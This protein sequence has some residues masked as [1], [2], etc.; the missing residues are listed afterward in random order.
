MPAAPDRAPLGPPKQRSALSGDG[1]CDLAAC[2]RG[3]A[4]QQVPG[5]II[6]APTRARNGGPTVS[7]TA[8]EKSGSLRRA[9]VTRL[10]G[11]LCAGPDRANFWC[12]RLGWHGEGRPARWR[13]EHRP[14]GE[15]R[16][17]RRRA[18]PREGKRSRAS[19]ISTNTKTWRSPNHVTWRSGF[20]GDSEGT[21]ASVRQAR[22]RAPDP[23]RNAATCPATAGEYP[24]PACEASLATSFQA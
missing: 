20:R 13:V 6:A 3:A 22:F 15:M 4:G 14:C 21:D 5:V 16:R 11:T 17:S 19:V 7:A 10:S 12:T 2:V 1:R 24:P 18:Q 23:P 8:R 9:P